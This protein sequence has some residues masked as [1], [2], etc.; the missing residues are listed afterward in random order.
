VNIQ[1]KG[2]AFLQM[3]F[4]ISKF[5]DAD[6]RALQIGQDPNGATMGTCPFAHH[7]RSLHVVFGGTMRK[8]E[9]DDIDAR[10]DQTIDDLHIRTGRA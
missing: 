9:A 6:F 1:N 4:A 3:N 8:I 10:L 2:F 5:A 7:F